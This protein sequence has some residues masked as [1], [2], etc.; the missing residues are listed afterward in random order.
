MAL[1]QPGAAAGDFERAFEGLE[2]VSPVYVIEWKQALM[3]AG[4]PR[5]ALA[6]LARG[7]ARLGPVPAVLLA[8]AELELGRPADALRWLDRLLDH[9]PQHPSGW[10]GGRTSSPGSGVPPRRET[11]TNVRLPCS[12]REPPGGAAARAT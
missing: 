1:D 7:A 5:A 9:S 2:P 4:E 12:S 10:H 3:A 8:A 6:A 11:P